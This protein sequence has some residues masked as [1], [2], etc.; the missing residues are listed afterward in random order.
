MH[1]ITLGSNATWNPSLRTKH[2]EAREPSNTIQR[3]NA[4]RMSTARSV[5]KNKK[6]KIDMNWKPNPSKTIPRPG[7]SARSAIK[8]KEPNSKHPKTTTD[9]FSNCSRH[10]F[11][12]P[13]Q[14]NLLKNHPSQRKPSRNSKHSPS[15]HSTQTTRIRNPTPET[16]L[17]TPKFSTLPER[18]SVDQ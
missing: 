10:Q 18:S 14:L 11:H 3:D 16:A 9:V 17:T 5:V 6:I 7:Q 1:L 13:K 2:N 4:S 15:S 12:R 8:S